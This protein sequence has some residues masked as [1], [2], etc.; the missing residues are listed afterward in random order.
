MAGEQEGF[1][2]EQ[3]R[4][5][6]SVRAHLI[7][8]TELTLIWAFGVVGKLSIYHKQSHQINDNTRQPSYLPPKNIKQASGKDVSDVE[9]ILARAGE[10]IYWSVSHKHV[11][12]SDDCVKMK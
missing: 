6:K 12:N 2:A 1:M 8:A 10:N 9:L 7:A 3:R 11:Y 4:V 5:Y